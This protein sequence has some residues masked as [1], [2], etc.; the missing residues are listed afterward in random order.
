MIAQERTKSISARKARISPR[1]SAIN[2]S[3]SLVVR[4]DNIVE[5]ELKARSGSQ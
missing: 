4:D 5:H 1:P 3:R 2:V